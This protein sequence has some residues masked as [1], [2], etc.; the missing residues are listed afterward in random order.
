MAFQPKLLMERS[1]EIQSHPCPSDIWKSCC[2]HWGLGDQGQIEGG[3]R[4]LTHSMYIKEVFPR[5]PKEL[6]RK[7]IVF[8]RIVAVV[9]LVRSTQ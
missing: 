4:S 3:T 9:R 7:K 8:F 6:L 1:D 5:R 2:R